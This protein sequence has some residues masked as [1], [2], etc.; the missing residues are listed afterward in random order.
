M[1]GT[2][3]GIKVRK[4]Y[5]HCMPIKFMHTCLIISLH[6]VVVFFVIIE[7]ADKYMCSYVITAKIQNLNARGTTVRCSHF[8]SL[9]SLAADAWVHYRLHSF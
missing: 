1:V 7:R 5:S 4:L 9:L 8:P 3:D 2:Y 6:G